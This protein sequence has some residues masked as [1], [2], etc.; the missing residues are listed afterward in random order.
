MTLTLN[1]PLPSDD[2]Q[3]NTQLAASTAPNTPPASTRRQAENGQAPAKPHRDR[4]IDLLRFGCLVVV[5]ILHSMMSAAVLGP[6]GTVEP[7]V[8]LSNTAGFAAASWFFQIMPLFFIIGGYAGITGWRRTR[9]RGGT[10]TDYLRARLRRIVVPV[11]VLIGLAGLGLSAAGELGVSTDLLAEASLRIGQPLWFLAVYVGLT[12]LVPVAVHFHETAPRRSLAALASAVIVVDGLVAVTGVTGLGY[13]NFLFVWPLV[14]QL[15]FFYADALDRP[16]RRFLAWA[17][18]A[19]ALLVLVGLVSAGV[20][21]PNM[22]VNLNPPTGALV[23]LGVVQLCGMRLVH[24]RLGRMLNAA[25]ENVSTSEAALDPRALRTQIWGRVITWGNRYGMH[26]YLWHMSIVIVLIGS[27]GTLAQAVS[28]VPGASDFVLP[29]IG[30]SW[31]WATRLPW[32]VAVMVLSS[33]VAMAAERIP[34]P[35]EQRLASIGRTIVEV[36]REMRGK[37][38]LDSDSGADDIT[39]VAS[40]AGADDVTPAVG[41]PRLRA[42]IAVGT[43]TAG[44]V[45]ALLVGIAPL[46]WTLVAFGLLMVSLILSAGLAPRDARVIPPRRPTGR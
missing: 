9:A 13:L 28:F 44:V 29:E 4:V 42:A 23:L 33:L 37:G 2:P 31:W 15:G 30:S 3:E 39:P 38:S 10:W 43:A 34:F 16:V 26:V 1:D 36:A 17:V 20:Y 40:Q 21:S 7:V 18:L 45:V 46:I 14:Q 12:A 19:A 25:D 5:V 22:L 41:C 8:A 11:A 27:L 35:S 24:A 6:S 32:L